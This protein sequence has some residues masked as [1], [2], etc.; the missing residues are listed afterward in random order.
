MPGSSE[1]VGA[2]VRERL[3]HPVVDA[4]GHCLEYLPVVRELIAE[5]AGQRAAAGFWATFE[6]ARAMAHASPSERRA[7]GVMRPPWWAF[8]ASNT[9]DRATAMLPQL[10]YERMDELGLDFAVI[11]PTFGL[12]VFNLADEEIRRGSARGLNRYFAQAYQGLSDRLTPVAVIPMHTPSEAID[13]LDHA[14]GELGMKTVLL[15]GHVMRDVAAAGRSAR[16]MQWMDTFGAD[17]DYDYDPVWRR[18]EEL[19]VSP[20][21]HSSGMGW[22]SRNSPSSYVFNHLGNFAAGGEAI[23]R[24]LFLDGVPVRFPRLRFAFLEGGVAWAAVLHAELVAHFEKRNARAVVRYDHERIDRV[25]LERLVERYGDERL[26]A[27]IGELDD[28]LWPF[29]DPG[30][31]A[32]TRDEFAASAVESGEGLTQVFTRAFYFG[33]EADDPFNALAFDP[34]RNGGARLNAMF[35]SDIGHWDVPD[36]RFVLAEAYES[37]GKK[38]L[39][40]QDFR[41]LTFTNPVSFYTAADRRFFAGTVVEAEAAC[42]VAAGADGARG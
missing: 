36:D 4:D 14:V 25:E 2:R 9:L 6:G 32:S 5:C 16:P 42:V 30:G 33:C 1:R 39:S 37:V 41:D 40:D 21:F 23:C 38:L 24:A 7:L 34:G 28:A 11:Y 31:T 15:A 12:V 3:D 20:T 35:S 13:E 17:G 19:G 27:R 29:S 26:Q 22:G 18:C 10:L 8:P